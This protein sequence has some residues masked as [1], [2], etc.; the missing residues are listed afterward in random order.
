MA[1]DWVRRVNAV[2]A[3]L[4]QPTLRKLPLSAGS[5][6]ETEASS[7]TMTSTAT[8]RGSV[9]HCSRRESIRPA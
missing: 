4:S 1:A 3:P 6:S 8:K 7:A 2:E 5:A 9:S